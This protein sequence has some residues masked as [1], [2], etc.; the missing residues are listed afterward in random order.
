MTLHFI[1]KLDEDDWRIYKEIRLKALKSDPF[2]FGSN[3]ETESKWSEAEW[4]SPLQ[5]ADVAI[6][7]LFEKGDPIGITGVSV[8]RNDKSKQTGILWGSWL[9]PAA[10]GKGL[11]KMFYEARINW[12]IGHSTIKRLII[13]HRASNLSSKF[14]NQK[15]GFIPTHITEKLWNDNV[16]ESEFHYELILDNRE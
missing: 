6:F 16:R 10:R 5:K 1:R 7:T 13:S 14:A 9:E 11:S 2:V 8:D 15:F 12:A 4:R 3:F